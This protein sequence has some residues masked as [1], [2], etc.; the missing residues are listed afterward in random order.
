MGRWQLAQFSKRIGAMSLLKVT[1][2]G[3]RDPG[4]GT[5]DPGSGIRDPGSG[6]RDPGLAI[7][8]SGF[9]ALFSGARWQAI[10][11][12]RATPNPNKASLIGS[13]SLE[14]DL[15]CDT[16]LAGLTG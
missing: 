16:L 15:S 14:V 6:I 8:P 13:W 12:A 11:K 1:G 9:D 5:R 2:L 3:A 7:R 10:S 4:S